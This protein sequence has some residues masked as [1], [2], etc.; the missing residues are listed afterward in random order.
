MTAKQQE[1]QKYKKVMAN[2]T[3]GKKEEKKNL[4]QT[5]SIMVQKIKPM[6]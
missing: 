3:T 6:V 1:W 5:N 4:G 2:K